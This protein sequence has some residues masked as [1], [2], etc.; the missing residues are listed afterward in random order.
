M[1]NTYRFRFLIYLA[2]FMLVMSLCFVYAQPVPSRNP[3]LFQVAPQHAGFL[4]P[5]QS[6]P[7]F[8][9]AALRATTAVISPQVLQQVENLH[10]HRGFFHRARKGVAGFVLVNVPDESSV[11]VLTLQP[12]AASNV[13]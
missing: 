6:A 3:L 9:P 10:A 11:V 12:S 5:L 7:S 1:E 4:A 13:R 2:A 8:D